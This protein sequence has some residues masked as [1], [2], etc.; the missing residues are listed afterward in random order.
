MLHPKRLRPHYKYTEKRQYY[1]TEAAMVVALSAPNAPKL[2]TRSKPTVHTKLSSLRRCAGELLLM[3]KW[4]R[5]DGFTLSWKAAR[6][7]NKKTVVEYVLMR[8]VKLCT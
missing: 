1:L 5:F 3:W 8:Q 6:D 2:V 4:R 7:M